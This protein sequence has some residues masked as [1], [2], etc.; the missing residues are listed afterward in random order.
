M[1]IHDVFYFILR[2]L[3][4]SSQVWNNT[5]SLL[6]ELSNNPENVV[7]ITTDDKGE[8][9]CLF[10]QLAEQRKLYQKYGEVLQLDGTH[11]ITKLAMPLY[12]LVVQDNFGVGQP[13]AFFL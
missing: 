10:I 5:A 2:H 13:D 6:S 1:Y 4:L 8:I 12:T 11:N 9:R 3:G 7:S